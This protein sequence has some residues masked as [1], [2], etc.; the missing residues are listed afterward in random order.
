MP[1][2][3]IGDGKIAENVVEDKFNAFV[4]RIDAYSCIFVRKHIAVE[5]AVLAFIL[6]CRQGFH[7]RNVLKSDT[8][9]AIQRSRT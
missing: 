5:E 6:Q 3:L 8:Y 7:E 9:L 4:P 2:Y 1:V